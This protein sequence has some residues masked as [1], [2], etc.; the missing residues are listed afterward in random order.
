LGL[1]SAILNSVLVVDEKINGSSSSPIPYSCFAL[2]RIKG[3]FVGS[4]LP[5]IKLVMQITSR[6]YALDLT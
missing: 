5:E 3:K 2:V 4:S 6:G 1:K